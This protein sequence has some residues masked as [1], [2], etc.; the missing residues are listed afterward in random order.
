VNSGGIE[1][2]CRNSLVETKIVDPNICMINVLLKDPLKIKGQNLFRRRR[3]RCR[4]YNC[5]KFDSCGD[6]IHQFNTRHLKGNYMEYSRVY[7]RF[8]PWILSQNTFENAHCFVTLTT[9]E[10]TAVSVLY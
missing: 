2:D 6:V 10:I 4:R 9:I 3:R 8:E 1:V 5:A 7:I